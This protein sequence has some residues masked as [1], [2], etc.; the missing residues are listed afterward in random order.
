MSGDYDQYPYLVLDSFSSRLQSEPVV[1]Y[2]R[3]RKA[4]NENARIRNNQLND[5]YGMKRYI[6]H[7]VEEQKE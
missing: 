1:G 7:E 4:A 3:T 6:I 2:Y 5:P